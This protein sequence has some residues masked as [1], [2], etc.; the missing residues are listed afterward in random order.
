M[1]ISDWSS[2]VCSSDLLGEISVNIVDL[3]DIARIP[4]INSPKKRGARPR[5]A[6]HG[7]SPVDLSE[8]QNWKV[9]PPRRPVTLLS[10]PKVLLP[11]KKRFNRS[12][13]FASKPA[14]TK[15]KLSGSAPRRTKRSEE[16][17]ERKRSGS[18]KKK[19]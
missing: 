1:R 12:A 5:R 9:T 3:R 17:R 14:S 6:P 7:G 18:K 10:P 2:D 8:D 19:R 15:P 4:H 11:V 13:T 16:R